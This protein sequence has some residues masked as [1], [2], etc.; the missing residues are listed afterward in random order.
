[1]AP[2]K[3]HSQDKAQGRGVYWMTRAAVAAESRG[4]LLRRGILPGWLVVLAKCQIHAD[5]SECQSQQHED[6]IA[7]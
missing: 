6:P 4:G 1:M 5:G 3:L 7:Q 2:S